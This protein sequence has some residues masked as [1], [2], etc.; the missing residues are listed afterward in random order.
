MAK[1]FNTDVPIQYSPGPDVK[2]YI[3]E[4]SAT[5]SHLSIEFKSRIDEA[6]G[7]RMWA[8]VCPYLRVVWFLRP[9]EMA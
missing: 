7:K 8:V 1:E 4:V 9:I 6:T 5:I 3:E 2:D